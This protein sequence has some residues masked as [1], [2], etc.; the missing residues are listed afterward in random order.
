MFSFLVVDDDKDMAD[1]LADVLRLAEHD[2]VVAYDGR[3]ALDEARRFH[4]EVVILDLNMPGLDGYATASCFL[5]SQDARRPVLI[6]LTAA[7]A[8]SDARVNAMKSGFDGFLSK[9]ANPRRILELAARLVDERAVLQPG[10]VDVESGAR[11]A[12]HSF[13]SNST[14]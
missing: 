8:S 1:S 5:N 7:S 2:C 4:V 3:T 13:Q 9:P 14:P 6:A 12:P 10:S 11:P